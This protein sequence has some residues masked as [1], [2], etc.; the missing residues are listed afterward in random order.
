MSL[1]ALS[2]YSKLD[3]LS[4]TEGSYTQLAVARETGARVA[5]KSLLTTTLSSGALMRIQYEASLLAQLDSEAYAS[6]IEVISDEDAIHIVS[7]FSRGVSLAKRVEVGP[8]DVKDVLYIAH[9]ILTGLSAIHEKRILHRAVRPSHI[10]VNSTGGITTAKLIDFG[11]VCTPLSKLKDT[12][13]LTSHARYFSPEQSGSI[14]HDLI[15]ASDLYSLGATLFEALAGYPPYNGSDLH[16]I[17]F[18]HMTSSVPDLRTLG[19]RVPRALDE[20]IGRLLR[21]DPRERYQSA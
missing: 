6:P 11:S 5:I 1:K 16:T 19:L 4:E 12:S 18:K 20:V 21:K 2:K 15:E 13:R 9:V 3:T 7:R 14:D 8:L 10:L 17:L